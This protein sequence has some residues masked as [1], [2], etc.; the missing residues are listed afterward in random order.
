MSGFARRL[1]K[2]T[3]FTRPSFDARCRHGTNVSG[4]KQL[5][6]ESNAWYFIDCRLSFGTSQEQ[7]IKVRGCTYKPP[8]PPLD[9][10]LYQGSNVHAGDQNN[11]LDKET[12]APKMN[13]V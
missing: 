11:F 9:L 2:N 8:P 3:G 1:K 4:R 7:R 10:A 12:I 5:A 6:S 13:L